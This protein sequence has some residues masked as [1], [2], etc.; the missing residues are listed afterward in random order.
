MTRARTDG[1]GGMA[2]APRYSEWGCGS[3]S[4]GWPS[5][6]GSPAEYH[7]RPLNDEKDAREPSEIS[8][9]VRFLQSQIHD[10]A[11]RI[12]GMDSALGGCGHRGSGVVVVRPEADIGGERHHE[13]DDDRRPQRLHHGARAE[14]TCCRDVS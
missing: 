9:I 1:S 14:T 7:D 8:E 4:D 12:E 3:T 11:V 10:R 13:S 6:V 5:G 2:A